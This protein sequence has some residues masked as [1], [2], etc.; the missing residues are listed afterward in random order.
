MNKEQELL[1]DVELA[2]EEAL[3]DE[4]CNA[5]QQYDYF[6]EAEEYE[7]YGDTFVSTGRYLTEESEWAFRTNFQRDNDVDEFIEKL[8]LNPDFKNALKK[9]IEHYANT[10]QI[11]R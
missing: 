10:A 5:C 4:W 7:A 3:E 1:E 9:Y 11:W 8:K 2:L 6:Q